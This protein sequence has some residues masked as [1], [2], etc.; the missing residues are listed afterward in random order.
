MPF[1]KLVGFEIVILGICIRLDG[2]EVA[3][4]IKE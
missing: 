2:P 4:L 3:E 1:L